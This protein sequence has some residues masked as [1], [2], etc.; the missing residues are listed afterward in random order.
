[1][2]INTTSCNCPNGTAKEI[3]NSNN[4]LPYCVSCDRGYRLIHFRETPECFKI[5]RDDDIKLTRKM[6]FMVGIPIWIFL[7]FGL[8]SSFKNGLFPED[9]I[10]SSRQRTKLLIYLLWVVLLVWTWKK[11]YDKC[12]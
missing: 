11:V 7:S 12:I 9:F 2:E 10:L 3:C 6:L 5:C 1:M 8:W 4:S